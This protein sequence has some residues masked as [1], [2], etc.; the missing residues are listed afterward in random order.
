MRNVVG[1]VFLS[2]YLVALIRPISPL[3]EY[4]SNKDFFAKVL[5]INQDKP[6]LACNGQ[7]ILMQKLKKANTDTSSPVSDVSIPKINL[8]DYPI[9]FIQCIQSP[10]T[11]L[12]GE[13][14]A[15]ANPYQNQLSGPVLREIFHPPSHSF[16]C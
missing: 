12:M 5:C 1:I 4:Y 13:R 9:G 6:A 11:A 14:D 16:V 2:L 15:I 7:C 8:K 3:L 10:A